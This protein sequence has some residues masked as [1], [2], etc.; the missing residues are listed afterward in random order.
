MNAQAVLELLVGTPSVSGQEA[1]LAGAFS[2]RLRAEGFD[3]Q[4]SGNNLWFETGGGGARLLLNSHLDTVPAAMGW[5]RDPLRL[6]REGDRCYG[7]GANDAKGCVAAMTAAALKLRAGHPGGTVIFAFTAEEETGGAGVATILDR[8]G[9]L[10]SAVIGE[11]TGLSVCTEQR[12]MLLLH[13]ISRGRA[14]HAAHA[15]PDENAVHVAARDIAALAALE[16]GTD[17]NFGPLRPQVT[18][19]EGG[20]LRNQVPGSCEF[21][22][23]IRTTPGLDH[24]A[25]VAGLRRDLRSEVR[26]HSSRYLPKATPAGAPV[27]RAALAAGGCGPSASATTSDW[28]FLGPVPAVKVGPGDTQRSHAPDEYVTV[29]ELERGTEFYEALVREYFAERGRERAG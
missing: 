12:G 1:A 18:Q 21:F 20:A 29:P 10:D 5:R 2:E 15:N 19:V 28:A 17:S 13:C 22:V 9:P 25:L 23:D 27:L 4:R 3:V 26:I 24:A 14:A 16:F 8:I 11:P 6:T 7:L